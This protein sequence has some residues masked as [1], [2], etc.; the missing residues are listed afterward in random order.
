MHKTMKGI[1]AWATMLGSCTCAHKPF[2]ITSTS[3]DGFSTV[4]IEDGKGN[5]TLVCYNPYDSTTIT[6]FRRSDGVKSVT[7]RS[8][9]DGKTLNTTLHVLE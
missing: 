1:V 9:C 7:V 8:L 5:N 4:E 2:S 3:Q 6:S